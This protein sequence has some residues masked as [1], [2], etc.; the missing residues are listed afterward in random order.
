MFILLTDSLYSQ[1]NNNIFDNDI[2][3]GI[4]LSPYRYRGSDFVIDEYVPIEKEHSYAD[5]AG[6]DLVVTVVNPK[7][8]IEYWRINGQF[9]IQYVVINGNTDIHR[10][11]KY[12]GETAENIL[13]YFN[14]PSKRNSQEIYYESSDW[15]YF[16][17]F[18][19][20]KGKI[21]EIFFGFTI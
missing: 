21:I 3:E 14:K 8:E 4:A 5:R 7:I 2:F 19:I 9:Q 20:S 17:K 16:V 12:I 1:V 11:G 10:F 6:A 15:Q 18:K 13:K